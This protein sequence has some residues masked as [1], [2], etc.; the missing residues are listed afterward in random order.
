[1]SRRPCAPTRWAALSSPPPSS[2]SPRLVPNA[3]EDH[4]LVIAVEYPN[5]GDRCSLHSVPVDIVLIRLESERVL[6]HLPEPRDDRLSGFSVWFRVE[7][8]DQDIP[9]GL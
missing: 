5:D 4:C 6:H 8:W 2:R 7:P 3:D 9:L 1:M